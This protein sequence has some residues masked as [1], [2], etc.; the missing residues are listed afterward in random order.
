MW[1]YT[2]TGTSSLQVPECI[3][4]VARWLLR[5]C[6]MT[7]HNCS[8]VLRKPV[9]ATRHVPFRPSRLH[10][11]FKHI[12]PEMHTSAHGM[13]PTY[14]SERELRRLRSRHNITSL[15]VSTIYMQHI[16]AY[17]STYKHI[18]I[19]TYITV[20]TS[21]SLYYSRQWTAASLCWYQTLASQRA[22]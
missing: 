16:Q 22:S 15:T 13:W 17:T 12:H 1:S 5:S 7:S 10:V 18:Y 19:A 11:L 3:L 21:K 6:A 14:R 8:K 9:K 4:P 20:N 2:K